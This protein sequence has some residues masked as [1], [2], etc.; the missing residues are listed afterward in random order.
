[1]PIVGVGAERGTKV[2]TWGNTKGSIIYWN[3]LEDYY[4][5]VGGLSAG[6]ERHRYAI[7]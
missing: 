4:L 3:R 5:C 7:A 2:G 1:M 6:S